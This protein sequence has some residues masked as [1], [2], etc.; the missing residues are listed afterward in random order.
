MSTTSYPADRNVTNYSN[1]ACHKQ[2][3]VREQNALS[4]ALCGYNKYISGDGITYNQ[5]NPVYLRPSQAE[6]NKKEKNDI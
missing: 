3:S 4:V 6:R 2:D 1:L 5:L